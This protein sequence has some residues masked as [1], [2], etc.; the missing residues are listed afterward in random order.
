MENEKNIEAISEEDLKNVTGGKE[1][2]NS[3]ELW[4]E[5]TD[6]DR[7]AMLNSGPANGVTPIIFTATVNGD[8]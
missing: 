4:F 5:G 7:I 2:I 1:N 6:V 3:E 8:K